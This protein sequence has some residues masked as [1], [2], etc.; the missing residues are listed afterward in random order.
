MTRRTTRERLIEAVLVAIPI[1]LVMVFGTFGGDA[2]MGAAAVRTPASDEVLL[3]LLA[4]PERAATFE[5]E[6]ALRERPGDVA[7]AVDVAR[8]HIE[9]ARR[10]NN[11]R[12]LGWAEA[13]LAPFANDANVPA[14]VRVLR[15]TIRQS[16]HDFAAA[17]VDLDAVLAEDP[18]NV[19]AALTRATIY[20]VIGRPGDARA[21]CDALRQ[22]RAH[23]SVEAVCHAVLDGLTGK[24]E[25]GRARLDEWLSPDP[26]HA[27]PPAAL[28]GWVLG[29]RA[30][31]SRS[32]GDVAAA[33]RDLRASLASDP[34]DAWTQA[35]LADLLLDAGRPAEVLP[36]IGAS[37]IDNLVLRRALAEVAL[38]GLRVGREG[39]AVVD[40]ARIAADIEALRGRFAAAHE[41]EDAQ[42][43][44]EEARFV[45]AIEHD[46]A[47]ALDL[48]VANWQHQKEIGDARI[49]LE[50]ALAARQP[51]RARP[52]L[53]H[54][55]ATGLVDAAL[56][57]L[58]RALAEIR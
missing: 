25:A 20:G 38:Q 30:D 28:L 27:P 52:V 34:H 37:D 7:L 10:N 44:R 43:L 50:T 9:D 32:L 26:R 56:T 47:R 8:R 48:A 41:R 19:Q 49:L 42:H 35:T 18:I 36:V 17:L 51:T 5:R 2:A 6:A 22:G 12:A 21:D 54:M 3:T 24:A 40:D 46:P 55:Q 4:D 58:V 14:A 23:P 11:P 31:L 13:V 15:A 16:R 53:D 57:P 45:L 29:T 33:E 39:T 1:V